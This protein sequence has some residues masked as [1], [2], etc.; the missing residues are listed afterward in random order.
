[1]VSPFAE[2]LGEPLDVGVRRAQ[3]ERA[4]ARRVDELADARTAPSAQ[5][6]R[7]RLGS[8]RSLATYKIP[9][10]RQSNDDAVC[11]ATY[12]AR[13]STFGAHRRRARP[14]CP[15]RRPSAV[16]SGSRAPVN[17][18]APPSVA[19]T[20][21]TGRC[22]SRNFPIVSPAATGAMRRRFVRPLRSTHTTSSVLG[23]ARR[24]RT[25]SRPVAS[26]ATRFA[27]SFPVVASCALAAAS[28]SPPDI[29]TSPS[30][31]SSGTTTVPSRAPR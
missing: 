31:A 1:M 28:R 19:E 3:H 27:Y 4:A 22:A 9:W 5:S 2:Q 10:L 25:S 18:G 13:R 24:R 12:R 30:S 7:A 14:T 20:A 21:I 26:R 6:S 11:R 16:P 29:S 23:A 17:G 15:A 8:G